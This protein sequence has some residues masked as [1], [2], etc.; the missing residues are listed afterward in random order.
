[1]VGEIIIDVIRFTPADGNLRNGPFVRPDFSCS[2]TSPRRSAALLRC[3][4]APDLH[5]VS[6]TFRLT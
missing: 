6:Q 5:L 2:A 4:S 3:R 1:M